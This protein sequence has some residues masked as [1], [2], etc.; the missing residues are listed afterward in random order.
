MTLR[1]NEQWFPTKLHD[2]DGR[3]TSF[4]WQVVWIPPL[5]TDINFQ[6]VQKLNSRSENLVSLRSRSVCSSGAV[7]RLRV[8]TFETIGGQWKSGAE[9]GGERNFLMSPFFFFFSSFLTNKQLC[10][11]SPRLELCQFH[12]PTNRDSDSSAVSAVYLA[13]KSIGNKKELCS[14]SQFLISII[15]IK[16]CNPDFEERT[17]L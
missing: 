2:V 3:N 10:H 14:D 8:A 7:C 16:N 15:G 12:F 5:E 13:L 17:Q 4:S 6:L 1:L 11:S 9:R